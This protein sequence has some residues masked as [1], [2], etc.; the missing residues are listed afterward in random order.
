MEG[1]KKILEQLKLEMR[2]KE[3]EGIRL[4]DIDCWVGEI[5]KAL[6]ALEEAADAATKLFRELGWD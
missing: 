1:P 4:V 2:V 5:D 6:I 3:Q